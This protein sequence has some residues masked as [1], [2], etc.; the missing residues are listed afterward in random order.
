[1]TPTSVVVVFGCLLRRKLGYDIERRR[2]YIRDTDKRHYA[3][4]RLHWMLTLPRCRNTPPV[5]IVI[6]KHHLFLPVRRLCDTLPVP[7]FSAFERKYFNLFTHIGI[8][9]VLC[10]IRAGISR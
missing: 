1:M 4:M 5:H 2:L 6:A 9:K 3:E 7:N 8:V 10:P